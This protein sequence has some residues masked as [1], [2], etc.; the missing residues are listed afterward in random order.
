[1]GDEIMNTISTQHLQRYH[2]RMLFMALLTLALI[3]AGTVKSHAKQ[4]EM[5]PGCRDEGYSFKHKFL[6]LH[7][8]KEGNHQSLYMIHNTSMS[9]IH[10]YHARNDDD[11]KLQLNNT[12]RPNQWGAFSGNQKAI[13]FIC[14]KGSPHSQYGAIVN[15]KDVVRLCEYTNVKF[16]PNAFGNYWSVRS[17]SKK[18]AIYDIVRLQGILLR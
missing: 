6:I 18:S 16:A 2:R 11:A 14:T 8:Q 13:E 15:C 12:I 1:M 9:N 7:P 17:K 4:Y 3:M 10:F 5:P